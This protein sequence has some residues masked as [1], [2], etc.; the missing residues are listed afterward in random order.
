MMI[1]VFDTDRRAHANIKKRFFLVQTVSLVMK[2]KGQSSP[3][4]KGR[5]YNVY[6][7]RFFHAYQ[8][9]PVSDVVRIDH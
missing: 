3:R 6:H 8:L 9:K 5:V 4:W 2:S 1:H 7:R